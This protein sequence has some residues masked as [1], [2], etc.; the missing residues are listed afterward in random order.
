MKIL[1]DES[2]PR[3]LKND[4]GT[5]H[6]VWTVRDK[7]WLGQKNGALLKLMVENNFELFVTVDRNLQYQQNLEQLPLT[8]IVL[9][10]VDNRRETLAKL[11]PK[12]FDR[13]AEGNSQNVIEIS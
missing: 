8:I 3:K 6:E 4:F 5:Q 12:L 13:L 1:L 10:A 2:L 9:S 7:D 11:I